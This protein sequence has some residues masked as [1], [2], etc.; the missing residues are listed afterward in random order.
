MSEK[1]KRTSAWFRIWPWLAAVLSGILLALSFPPCDMGGLAF[2]ALMPLL[3]AV[4]LKR[5][6]RRAGWYH[7]RLGYVT[8]LVF[9]TTT[10]SWL[11]EL[12]ELFHTKMLLGLPLLLAVFLALC[13]AAWA[14]FAGWIVGEHFKPAPLPMPGQPFARPPLLQST[15]NLLFSL[16]IAAAWTALE[17]VRGWLFCW[18]NLG[19]S[20]HLEIP[21]MQIVD[22]TG[23]G[24][25]SFLLVLC[26]AIGVITIL[27]LRAEIGRV[28]LRPHFDFSLTVALVV[29]VFSYGVRIVMHEQKKDAIKLSVVSIQ[30]NI[31]QPLK[32]RNDDESAGK[33]RETLA[34]HHLV[35]KLG[36]PHL[37]LWPEATVPGGIF[38]DAETEAWVLEQASQVPALLLGTDDVNRDGPGDDHNSAALFIRGQKGVQLY[39]KIHLV[40]FGEFVPFRPL[41]GWAVGD[42]VGGDF[43]AGKEP[44]VFELPVPGVKLGPLICF[45]DT[46][47][48]LARAP[49]KMGAQAFVN[50]TNDGWFGRSA[51]TQQHLVNAVFRSVENRRPMMRSTNTGTTASIDAFG[52][53]DLWVAPFQ[54]RTNPAKEVLLSADTSLTFFTRH[55]EVFTIVCVIIFIATIAMR[56]LILRRRNQAS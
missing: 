55:G 42:L 43:K 20:L 52:R 40:P 35:A 2:V 17:W 36:Q 23:V 10:F 27:R 29:V 44:R 12:A 19:V 6:A 38:S 21:L 32:M 7:F 48:N 49:V 34:K 28:R 54:G 18:N 33:I 25:L 13:P 1:D 31:P 39:D 5:P 8:G 56:A 51:E 37:T 14:W 9:F 53:V 46:D 16:L 30:P 50:L 41:L 45:E 47:S 11:S 3:F 4:W 15:R 26:N 22:I 24:G